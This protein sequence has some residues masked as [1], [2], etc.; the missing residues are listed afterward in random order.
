M[1]PKQIFIT[2]RLHYNKTLSVSFFI[3]SLTSVGLHWVNDYLFL[4]LSAYFLM[5]A[6]LH[7]RISN[8]AIKM[9]T[10]KKMR[11]LQ[12]DPLVFQLTVLAV[13]NMNKNCK[14]RTAKQTPARATFFLKYSMISSTDKSIFFNT[15]FTSSIGAI[16]SGNESEKN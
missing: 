5:R 4:G 15:P 7:L 10:L 12:M 2:L 13:K 11:I 16:F 6:S 9:R 1:W 14:K 8:M 3:S